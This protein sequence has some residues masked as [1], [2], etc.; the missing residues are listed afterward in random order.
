MGIEV[1][2]E[3]QSAMLLNSLPKSFENFSC[4]IKFQNESPD[5]GTIKVKIFK[6]YKTRVQKYSEEQGVMLI[7]HKHVKGIGQAKQDKGAFNKFSTW[8]SKLKCY[9][10]G[11]LGHRAA[12]C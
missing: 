8:K 2:K 12:D 9:E 7:K 10:S 6:E 4:A 1:N 11:K 3:L 5:V